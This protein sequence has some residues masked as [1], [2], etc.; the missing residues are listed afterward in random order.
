MSGLEF[1]TSI[2]VTRPLMPPGPIFRGVIF[3]TKSIE[4][5]WENRIEDEANN[6]SVKIF[7]IKYYLGFLSLVLKKVYVFKKNYYN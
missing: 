2:D 3:L 7:F 4:N 6:S 5:S 1:T